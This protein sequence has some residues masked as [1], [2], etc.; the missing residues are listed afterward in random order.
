MGLGWAAFVA[1]GPWLPSNFGVLGL[2]G[3]GPA[4]GAY[5]ALFYSMRMQPH[6]QRTAVGV[7]IFGGLHLLW[8]LG[9]GRIVLGREIDLWGESY[10]D[11]PLALLLT[12]IGFAAALG[13]CSRSAVTACGLVVA[14]LAAA[15]VAIAFS[16]SGLLASLFLGCASLHAMM[17]AVMAIDT[18]RFFGRLPPEPCVRCGYSLAQLPRGAPC[19]ECGRETAQPE[20]ISLG[21]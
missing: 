2:I 19:P 4:A 16:G 11:A 20:A 6:T 10:A 7:G 5:L 21:V 15:G 8:V 17:T 3:N 12:G 1:A 14:G 9:L 18:R 13:L